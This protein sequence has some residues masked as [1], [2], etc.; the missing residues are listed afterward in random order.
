MLHVAHLL[1]GPVSSNPPKAGATYRILVVRF[2]L[3]HSRT[4]F[5]STTHRK[6]TIKCYFSKNKIIRSM[7]AIAIG[8]VDLVIYHFFFSIIDP[9][10]ESV[11]PHTQQGR[12]S[13]PAPFER[14]AIR[15]L[16]G[17]LPGSALGTGEAP[18]P[19]RTGAR[20]GAPTQA[21]LSASN[22]LEVSTVY[23]ELPENPSIHYLISNIV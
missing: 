6:A 4:R 8:S 19:A 5:H 23:Y 11:G 7:Q 20:T 10:A 21:V 22:A 3:L 16:R 12:Y 17:G 9:S 13:R 18:A 14:L 2:V 15:G 1:R